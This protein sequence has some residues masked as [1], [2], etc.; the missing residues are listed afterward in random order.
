[1]NW[2]MIH[3]LWMLVTSSEKPKTRK[4]IVRSSED[5]IVLKRAMSRSRHSSMFKFCDYRMKQID[6]F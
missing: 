1:M 4:K 2:M 3:F 5:V 6:T